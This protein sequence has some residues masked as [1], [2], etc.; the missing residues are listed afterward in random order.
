MPPAPYF[1]EDGH[2]TRRILRQ[3]REYTGFY[4]CLYDGLF[5]KHGRGWWYWQLK[6]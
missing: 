4:A 5:R 1:P 2:H 3:A 6:P